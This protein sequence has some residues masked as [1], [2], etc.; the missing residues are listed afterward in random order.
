MI[1][2]WLALAAAPQRLLILD[3]VAQV[4]AS[5]IRAVNLNVAAREAILECEFSVSGPGSG[6]RVSLMSW[7]QAERF[8]RGLSHRTVKSLPY[9]TSG[10]LR[11]AIAG[12]GRYQL[13]LDNRLEGRGPAAVSMKVWLTF[14][15][16]VPVELSWRRRMTVAA[17]SLGFF[18]AVACF[19]GRKLWRAMRNR[20]ILSLPGPFA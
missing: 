19:V 18:F 10:L 8:R 7:D 15:Q 12:G 5:Q 3:E 9:A 16:T 13:V 1:L 17:I 6:I 4:P 20:R 2:V 11:T 14:G